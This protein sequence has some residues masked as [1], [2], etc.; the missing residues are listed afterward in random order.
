MTVTQFARLDQAAPIARTDAAKPALS[1]AEFEKYRASPEAKALLADF[2]AAARERVSA[3]GWG[4][5]KP[6]DGY[7][8]MGVA[9][10][11]LRP[12]E[13]PSLATPGFAPPGVN[14]PP[15]AEGL[16]ALPKEIRQATAQ[17][18]AFKA[19][20]Q[21]QQ[22]LAT[23][24]QQ[25]K[26]MQQTAALISSMTDSVDGLLRAQGATIPEPV[27]SADGVRRDVKLLVAFSMSPEGRAALEVMTGLTAK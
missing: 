11:K 4:A 25:P 14:G 21:A 13:I 26:S 22:V 8:L 3:G 19:S 2:D 24:D 10:D 18:D 15:K 9:E 16:A 23:W 12:L 17:L 6:S 27:R 20:P 1:V 7:A 5:G